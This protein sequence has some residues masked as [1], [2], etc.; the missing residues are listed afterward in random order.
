MKVSRMGTLQIF[1]ANKKSTL[2]SYSLF[3][4][5]L[6]T[7]HVVGAS[8]APGAQELQQVDL[9]RGL[10]EDKVVVWHAEAKDCQGENVKNV[11][12]QHQSGEVKTKSWA[13]EFTHTHTHLCT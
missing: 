12:Y 13:L 2:R 7:V 10:H 5:G 11:D 6:E 9:H 8:D 4:I 1:K 3:L